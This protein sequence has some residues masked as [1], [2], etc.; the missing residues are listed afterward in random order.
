MPIVFRSAIVAAV[1]LTL[2][3]GAMIPS[4]AQT[5]SP[6]WRHAVSLMEAP[7]YAD[8]FRHFDYVNPAAPKGG[9]VKLAAFGS[10]DSFNMTLP[11]GAVVA[12]IGTVYETLMTSSDDEI[13]AEYGLL[14]EAV[15]YPDDFASVTYRL[16]AGAKW[17]DGTPVTAQDVIWSLETLKANHP[18]YANYYHN[19]TKA[20]AR[21]DREVTFTFD[22][23]GNRELPQI[24]GQLIVLPKA[25]WTGKDAQGRMRDITQTTLE[26][27][28]G[29]GPYR[30]KAFVPGRSITYE[31]VTD[32]WGKDLPVYAGKNNFDTIQYEYFR[33]TTVAFE[34]FK[35]GQYDFRTESSAKDWATGYDFPAKREGKVKLDIFPIRNSGIMQAFAFN[36]RRDKFKDIRVRQ[37]FN[38]AMDFEDMNRTLFYDQ[39]TRI[40]SYF[41]NTELAS[42]GL[43]E[44]RERDILGAL[45]DQLPETIFTV[46]YQNS[47]GGSPQ[48]SRD[49]LRKAAELLKQAGWNQEKGHVLHNAKGEKLS[50]EF[51]LDQPNFERVALF[52]KQSLERLG[53]EV[54][55]RVVDSS[56]MENR[57]RAR[58]FDM[59]VASWPQSLSPGNEQRDFWGSEAARREG[60]RNYGGIENPAIDALIE[61]V[62][63]AKNRDDLVAAT[64]ALDRVLLANYYVVP[65]WT[66]KNLRFAYWDKFARPE[67]LP[68]YS[69][70]FP[71]IWWAK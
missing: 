31:R 9:S 12:G 38:L 46:P 58:D 4:A 64:R 41:E 49:N 11:R 69:L 7:K 65:Q 15:S 71:D 57:E 1:F 19:V 35:G 22:E 13:S 62:V 20:E 2:C 51:L 50:V 47:Q 61:K 60:S 27:P 3:A 44:G 14:A 8:G 70:G 33:D 10:F 37:A 34:A 25:W 24:V 5:P 16:R 45:K 36:L 53:I 55:I 23:K 30:I 6:V 18:F 48:T 43:P 54:S 66:S 63:Y 32:H 39:Y 26:V 68:D 67:K 42:S 40:S 56:Q 59:I 28:M 21:S 17:H 52:Y 29:S